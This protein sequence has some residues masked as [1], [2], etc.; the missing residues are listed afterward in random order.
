MTTAT[1]IYVESHINCSID[2]VWRHTQTPAVHE[3]WD[4]RFSKIDYLEAD[5]DSDA[6]EP[7]RFVYATAVAPG[8]SVDGRGETL[9]ERHRS[10]G[11]AY[12]GLKFWSDRRLSLIQ[13]GSGYWRYVPDPDG[14]VRFLTRYDYRVRWG[15]F[16][17]CI[18]RYAFR[19]LFGWAT[20]WSFDRLRLWIERGVSPERSRDQTIAHAVAVVTVAFVWIYQ[21]LVPKVLFP[22]S[23][24][25]EMVEATQLAIPNIR[26]FVGV[27]GVCEILFGIAVLR[28]WR[29]RWPFIL[30]MLGMPLLLIGA[31]LGDPIG[32][33]RPFNP[34]TLNIAMCALAGMALLTRNDLPSG[35]TPLRRAPH[36]DRPQRSKKEI[37]A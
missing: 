22:H 4:V 28:W 18:D 24:E 33:Q 12:S 14:G 2:D 17:R 20:A 25:L 6:D 35:E 8:I 11:T 34:V 32:L 16:G 9:G 31:L 37:A 30:T 3:R 26:L 15:A 1:P 36:A 29:Q 21:G 7:Q 5:P 27:L 19:P 23:G 10:D 13:S